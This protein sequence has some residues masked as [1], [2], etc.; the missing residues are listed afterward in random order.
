VRT[1]LT[2]DTVRP[3]ALIFEGDDFVISY[4]WKEQVEY[5]EGDHGF[6]FDAGWG[7]DPGIL[8]VPSR[9]IWAEVMP[10]WLVDRRAEVLQRLEA[11]SGH[12][13]AEDVHGIYRNDPSYRCLSRPPGEL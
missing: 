11:H 6:R 13:L 10:T 9:Q 3:V 12:E 4:P 7:V 2:G 5:W 8:I 1:T